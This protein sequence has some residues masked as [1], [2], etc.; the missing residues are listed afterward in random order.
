MFLEDLHYHAEGAFFDRMGCIDK[1]DI[2]IVW[3]LFV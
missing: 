3:W 1:T 2:S